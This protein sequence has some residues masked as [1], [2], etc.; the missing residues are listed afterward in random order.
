MNKE[1]M[2]L[3]IKILEEA[4][5]SNFPFDYSQYGQKHSFGM[6]WCPS[7]ILAL[8][9]RTPI[10]PRWLCAD[11]VRLQYKTQKERDATV[12]DTSALSH[13][14]EISYDDTCEIFHNAHLY[15]KN[16]ITPKEVTLP[17]VILL[18]RYYFETNKIPVRYSLP[19]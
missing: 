14:L 7:S 19:G 6:I 15:Y 17:H 18:M 2:E 13:W 10:E 16:K 12:Y 5:V 11:E 9:D 3:A 4:N 8:D 1:Q